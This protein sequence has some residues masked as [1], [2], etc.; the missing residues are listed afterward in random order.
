LTDRVPPDLGE[1]LAW[2]ASR[3]FA[4]Y[5]L[6]ECA[7]LEE[8]VPDAAVRW[9]AAAEGAG[10]HEPAGPG[11]GRGILNLGAVQVGGEPTTR[12]PGSTSE[13]GALCVF[14]RQSC[15]WPHC[16]QQ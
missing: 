12:A 15:F 6:A 14:R 2:E 3:A 10:D 5:W 8:Q 4:R 13:P 7:K 9:G 11:E 1:Q 16:R